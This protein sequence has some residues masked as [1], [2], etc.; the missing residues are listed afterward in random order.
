MSRVGSANFGPASVRGV[1]STPPTATTVEPS[2]SRERDRQMQMQVRYCPR[3]PVCMPTK[4]PG[5][6]LAA[7]ALSVS[8]SSVS[9]GG[10][11]A[12]QPGHGRRLHREGAGV[13]HGASSRKRACMADMGVG[14]RISTSTRRCKSS[15]GHAG[16]DG[17]AEPDAGAGHRTAPYCTQ[18]D[19]T[20]SPMQAAAVVS[21]VIARYGCPRHSSMPASVGG[22]R[23]GDS[24]QQT[25]SR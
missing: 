15:R 4:S 23:Q 11:T 24:S 10:T 6:P 7:A 1:K 21:A 12:S 20:K 8:L 18:Q 2:R 25:L 13:R 17:P 16:R 14:G 9:G 5:L 19:R 22:R 3:P